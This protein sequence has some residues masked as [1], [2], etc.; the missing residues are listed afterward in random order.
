MSDARLPDLRRALV[1]AAARLDGEAAAPAPAPAPRRRRG[2]RRPPA[3][4]VLVLALLAL[5]AVAAIGAAATGLLGQ[6]SDVQPRSG[7]PPTPK[8]GFG[9]PVGAVAPPLRVADPAGGD[10]DWGLR[11]F[12]TTRGFACL[13]L[14][15]MQGDR[16]G[17]V[18][19]DGAF[20]DDGLFHA[21]GPQVLDGPSC[22]PLDARGHGFVAIHN[23]EMPGSALPGSC[24]IP[25]FFHAFGGRVPPK[26]KVKPCDPARL[27]TVDYGLLGPRGK[28]ITY[29]L[30]SGATRTAAAAPGTGAFLIVAPRERL[31][32]SKRYPG[33]IPRD[34]YRLDPAPAAATL[35]SVAY[36]DGTACTVRG[37]TCAPKG[38][39]PL[40]VRRPSRAEV[41]TPVAARIERN[42]EGSFTLHVLFRARKT[43][44]Q[45]R[46]AYYVEVHPSCQRAWTGHELERDVAAGQRVGAAIKIDRRSCAGRYR[47]D[48]EYRVPTPHPTFGTGLQWPGTR[49]GS[50]TATLTK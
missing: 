27:R 24:L 45:A 44:T 50:A 33:M 43:A 9:V 5:L 7:K 10:L 1:D 11:T 26:M 34:A 30:P 29:R 48:V 41:A 25:S 35:V 32:A 12:R 31:T 38:Y 14:G 17:L 47:I 13:Q 22:V 6:G 20:Q 19:R 18:G 49:V 23:A 40:K 46:A 21:L 37:A 8:T 28:S 2:H 3:T 42:A 39:V 4:R 16:F 15:R 36:D